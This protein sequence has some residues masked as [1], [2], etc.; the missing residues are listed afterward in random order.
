MPKSI[1]TPIFQVFFRNKNIYYL[2]FI[3]YNLL[4]SICLVI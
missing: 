4:L 3:I 1:D 2:Q